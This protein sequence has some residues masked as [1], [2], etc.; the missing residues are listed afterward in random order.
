MSTITIE[1]RETIAKKLADME[2][3]FG[4]GDEKSACSVAA[5]N[6]ALRGKLSAEIPPCMSE[7]IGQ[8]I[9]LVQDGMPRDM[10]NSEEWKS[11]LPLAAGTGREKEEERRDVVLDWMW[12][13]VL[14]T[15]QPVADSNGF[16]DMWKY[17]IAMRTSSKMPEIG[18]ARKT[19]LLPE[20]VLT[21]VI[22]AAKR[23]Q[24]AERSSRT[25]ESFSYTASQV[26]KTTWTV[27][28]AIARYAVLC[29]E[30]SEEAIV[31]ERASKKSTWA[32]FNPC[33]LLKTLIEVK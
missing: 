2:L 8:W 23:A 29:K 11:L 22:D 30:T 6:I 10:R 21:R 7:V 13:I 14:P 4:L 19:A 3:S 20:F 18:K 24:Q 5:I 25:G 9:I 17:M 27:S 16:G 32:Q 12:R 28:E 31:A 33:A 26:A 1:Q 15:L